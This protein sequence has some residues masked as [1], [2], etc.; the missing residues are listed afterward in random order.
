[1]KNNPTASER[2]LRVASMVARYQR[3]PS[4]VEHERLLLLV[5]PRV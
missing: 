2:Q 5:K 3:K 1:M 4:A